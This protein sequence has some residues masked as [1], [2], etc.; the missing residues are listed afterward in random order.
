[1]CE[2]FGISSKYPIRCNGY[3]KDFFSHSPNQ[4]HGWGLAVL[5]GNDAE[6]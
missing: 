5:D 6:D 1:M 2:L 4:P 3:L